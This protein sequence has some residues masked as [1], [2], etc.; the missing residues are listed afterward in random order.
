[1]ERGENMKQKE[2]IYNSENDTGKTPHQRSTIMKALETLPPYLTR[3]KWQKLY[4]Q[5]MLENNV[6][7]RIYGIKCEF[8]LVVSV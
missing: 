8:I 6:K 7:H 4:S 2:D 5:D 1:M 3:G